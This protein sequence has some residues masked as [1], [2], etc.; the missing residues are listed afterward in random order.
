MA[1]TFWERVRGSSQSR[2]ASP[3]RLNARTASITASA[4][5]ITMCGASKRWLRASLSMEPQLGTGA[6]TPRPRKLSVDSARI[7]PAMPMVA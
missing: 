2:H 1:A 5:K 7:A 6:R 3:R 4:G